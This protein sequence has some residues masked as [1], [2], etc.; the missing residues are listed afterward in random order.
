MSGLFY[1]IHIGKTALQSQ[2]SVLNV[3]SHNVANA[4]TPGYSRQTVTLSAVPGNTQG[5]FISSDFSLGAGVDAEQVTR[6]RFAL[7]D[8]IYRN[9]NQDYN[10][11][12]TTEELLTQVELLF[13]E[14]SD[15]G[16]A[17]IL[18]DFYNSWQDLANDPQSMAARQ[19]VI[20]TAE[21]LTSRMHRLHEQLTIMQADVDNEIATIPERI[22]EISREIAD[23]N[24]SIRLSKSQGGTPNDLEDKRDLL[25]DE[26]T[27]YAEVRS[28]P[29]DDGTY[30]VILGTSVIVERETYSE[31]KAVTRSG[32]DIDTKKTVI[33]SE[34]GT[35]YEPRSGQL[36]ALLNFRDEIIPDIKDNLDTLAKSL[37]E[38]VNFEHSNGYTLNGDTDVNFFDPIGTKAFNI[39]LSQDMRDPE[40][41]A[42]SGDGTVGDNRNALRIIDTKTREVINQ[43]YTIS[44]YYNAMIAD[45]GILGSEAKSGRINEQLL[46]TQIDNAREGIKGV[47]IDEEMVQMI[48]SQQIYNAASRLIVTLDE[49]L[50]SV[51]AMT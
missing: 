11:F 25:V 45:I 15:R 39:K 26:L 32:G 36:G 31:L 27:N 50:E 48:Q 34:D 6:S 1:G 49:L 35:E 4:N 13:D 30:T 16:F 19:T 29:H 20:S 22:N 17:G 5:G 14:P 8:E 51:I 3:I 37:V 7:Y 2:T 24:V 42:V 44:E 41:I 12:I 33:V 46:V 43:S 40:N 10:A 47:S 18:D 9:E 23:L 21:E 38:T 28:V